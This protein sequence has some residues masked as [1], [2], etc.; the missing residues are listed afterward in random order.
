MQDMETQRLRRLSQLSVP[1][2]PLAILFGGM[3]AVGLR[4]PDGAREVAVLAVLVSPPF[5]ALANLAAAALAALF[6]VGARADDLL[7]RREMLRLRQRR[8]DTARRLAG[9]R[10]VRRWEAPPRVGNRVQE[11]R[12]QRDVSPEDL[13]DALEIR[14]FSLNLIE[15]RFYNPDFLLC[16]KIADFFGVPP[17]PPAAF[18]V[19]EPPSPPPERP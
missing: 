3:A 8:A 14:V 12:L 18:W 9:E 10:F 7:R 6:V 17:P 2:V 4:P 19:E 16:A 13:A 15:R 1:A 5:V 11:L